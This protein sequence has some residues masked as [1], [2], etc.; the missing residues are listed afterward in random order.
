[1]TVFS[2]RHVF[3]DLDGTL[4]DSRDAVRECYARV[5]RH[6]LNADF[7]PDAIPPGEIFA[8]RPIEL[9]SRFAPERATELY[10]AYHSTY[11]DCLDRVAVFPAVVEMIA[12]L[13]A[14]GRQLA[15]VTNKGRERTLLDLSVAGI[16]DSD[17]ATIVTAEDTRERKPHPAPILLALARTGADPADTVYVGDGPQDVLAARAAG[18]ACIALTYGFYP[19]EDLLPCAPAAV[20]DDP[21]NLPAVLG[22]RLSEAAS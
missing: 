13:K 20:V 22:V 4:V 11:P 18:M 7:P 21:R 1:M 15:L 8:M 16:A 19:R 9:F 14:A 3:F 10:D 2:C 12:S 5:Y 6:H 17:F